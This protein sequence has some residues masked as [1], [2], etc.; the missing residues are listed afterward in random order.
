MIICLKARAAVSLVHVLSSHRLIDF[1]PVIAHGWRLIARAIIL[2]Y[3]R[4]RASL[5][6]A[7][8]AHS[9][10]RACCGRIAAHPL[11][12][13]GHCRARSFAQATRSWNVTACCAVAANSCYSDSYG[14]YC[15]DRTAAEDFLFRLQPGAPERFDPIAGGDTD[16]QWVDPSEWPT[17]GHDLAMGFGNGAPGQN[18]GYCDQGYTYAGSDN[19]VCGGSYNW[20]RTDVE[21]WHLAPTAR[22]SH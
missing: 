11:T 16:Y 15:Y 12:A 21:A 1:N 3:A 20:G 22:G 13:C 4:N 9:F 17:W 2:I 10:A 5:A 7:A 6:R 19:E 18:N 8:P 14:P